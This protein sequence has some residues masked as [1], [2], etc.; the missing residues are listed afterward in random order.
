MQKNKSGFVV[1]ISGKEI[2]VNRPEPIISDIEVVPY[3]RRENPQFAVE[4]IVAGYYVLIVDFYS[5]GLTILKELKKYLN[6][7][8]SD[9]S[10]KG[11]RDYRSAFRKLSHRLLLEI[12]NHKLSVRK[13]PEIGWLKILYSELTGFLLP[14]PQVQGLNSSWQWYKKGILIPVSERKIHPWFG[15][16]FPTR[17]E[18]LELF[19]NWLKRYKGE[20]KS[21]FDIGIGSGILSFQML[22]HGFRKIYGTDSNPNAI[23]GLYEDLNKNNLSSKIELI[24]GDL[25]AGCNVK[26]ELIVFNPPWLPASYNSEGMDKA[27]YYDADLFTR[28]FEQAKKYLKPDGKVVF[29]F[30]NLAQITELVESHPIET[31]LSGGGRFEKELFLQKKV[32][33]ASENTRRNLDRRS[34][35]MVELWVL[36]PAE[37]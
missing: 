23:V 29:I 2:Q 8:Y 9:Q 17:F 13:A 37:I 25:F 32:R 20:K 11:Q 15:T 30:S 24:H 36:K 31:E 10:Y 21:A 26:T 5:S 27:V 33:S 12:N 34:S 3:K 1:T 6:K 14:V 22:K 16:Y 4:D 18:H 35:E 19:D 28:F 7:K